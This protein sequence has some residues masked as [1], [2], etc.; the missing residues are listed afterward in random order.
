VLLK[1]V[2]A[3]P[4]PEV[5]TATG[6][7]SQPL[8]QLLQSI[9]IPCSQG[10]QL[11]PLQQS[12]AVTAPSG[13]PANIFP[14]STDASNNPPLD[15]SLNLKLPPPCTSTG[16]FPSQLPGPQ[17]QQKAQPPKAQIMSHAYAQHV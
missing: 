14:P 9:P 17:Q 8:P 10:T 11:P 6:Q 4:S 2:Q 1:L 5:P 7:V 13:H 15:P 16:R 12:K 3:D